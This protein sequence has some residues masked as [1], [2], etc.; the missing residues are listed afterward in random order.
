MATIVV[1]ILLAA[2]AAWWLMTLNSLVSARNATQ[3]SW[4]NVEVE[5]KRRFDLIGNLIE[6][7]KGYAGHEKGT[8]EKVTAMRATGSYPTASDG[9]K[10]VKDMKQTFSQ[11]VALAEGYP[12]LKAN[13]QYLSLQSELAN[14]EN[15]IAERRNAYNQ[16]VNIYENIRL[17]VPSNF[18][19]NTHAFAPIA[20]FDAPDEDLHLPEVKLT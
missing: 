1:V 10:A 14:T 16:T 5:L 13:Q 12:D 9:S 4:S 11:V 8:L 15:R 19:A 20:F 18:V 3:Q 17:T 7:V 6:V 2:A